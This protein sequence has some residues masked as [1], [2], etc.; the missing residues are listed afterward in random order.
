MIDKRSALMKLAYGTR[1]DIPPALRKQFGGAAFQTKWVPDSTDGVK[2]VSGPKGENSQPNV[3][4]NTVYASGD[5]SGAKGSKPGVQP[6]D[7]MSF[8]Q[9]ARTTD[10]LPK[11]R[12]GIIWTRNGPKRFGMR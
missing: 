5:K 9:W 6:Y 7:W 4:T 11:Y 3:S 8:E 10:P 2:S 1:M 12:N